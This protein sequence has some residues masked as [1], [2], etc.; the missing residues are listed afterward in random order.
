M[1]ANPSVFFKDGSVLVDELVPYG[2]LINIVNIC[3][4]QEKQFPKSLVAYYSLELIQ[5]MQQ[6]HKCQIIHADLKPD[7]VLILNL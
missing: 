6:I 1:S 5:I 2:T 4:K 3:K 7:N